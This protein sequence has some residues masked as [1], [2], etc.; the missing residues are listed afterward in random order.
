MMLCADGLL[1]FWLKLAQ[2]RLIRNAIARH[3]AQVQVHSTRVQELACSRF[4]GSAA[5]RSALKEQCLGQD[6]RVQAA[7]GI[8]ICSI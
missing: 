1:I 6:T 5:L 3:C 4:T 2:C 8:D 7:A